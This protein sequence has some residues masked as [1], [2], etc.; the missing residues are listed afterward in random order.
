MQVMSKKHMRRYVNAFTFRLN[1]RNEEMQ[2]VFTDVEE[3]ATDGSQL[4]Y[5]EPMA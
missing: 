3:R 5:K 1:R 2:S 4:P